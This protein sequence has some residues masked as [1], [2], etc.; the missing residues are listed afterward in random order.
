ME[1]EIRLIRIIIKCKILIVF[2]VI[3]INNSFGQTNIIF[4]NEVDTLII[5]AYEINK[6][7]TVFKIAIDKH[8][9]DLRKKFF[10]PKKN[11]NFIYVVIDV[12]Y[13]KF[14]DSIDKLIESKYDFSKFKNSDFSEYSYL[15]GVN[16][17]NKKSKS[18]YGYIDL[19]R[20]FYYKYNGWDVILVSRLP[21]EFENNGFEKKFIL[22]I[23]KKAITKKYEVLW[24]I[25]EVTE[26]E[27]IQRIYKHYSIKH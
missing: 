23:S 8:K 27:V 16:F 14:N 18:N 4:S 3:S 17:T 24:S 20:Y 6:L 1:K 13:Q 7:D 2:F 12:P 22:P 19:N 5:N 11:K 9:K 21:I 25:Y 26:Y 10:F 15:L